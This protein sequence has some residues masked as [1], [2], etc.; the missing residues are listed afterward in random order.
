[1][2][3]TFRKSFNNPSAH[4]NAINNPEEL[5]DLTMSNLNDA[6][7][8]YALD[9]TTDGKFKAICLSGLVVGDN[10]GGVTAGAIEPAIVVGNTTTILVRPLQPFAETLPDPASSTSSVQLLKNIRLHK[11]F[12]AK[13]D[14]NEQLPSIPQFGE[15]VDCYYENGSISKSIYSNLRFEPSSIKGEIIP[16]YR[17]L[18]SMDFSQST[19]STF[20][21]NSPA[22]LG[23][24]NPGQKDPTPSAKLYDETD[25]IENK[26]NQI[27]KMN[28]NLHPV[29]ITYTKAIIY[30]IHSQ[31][32]GALYFASLYRSYQEQKEMRA[33]W[34]AWEN[35]GKIGKKPYAGRPAKAG[36]SNHNFGF[37]ADFAVGII[38]ANPPIAYNSKATKESW[39]ASGIPE[40]IESYGLRWGGR[41][42][43]NYD[44]IHFDIEL[45][46]KAT[47][48]I[49]KSTKPISN[50][51]SALKEIS[52]LSIE[53]VSLGVLPPQTGT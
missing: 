13:Y 3:A 38:G 24:P 15:I 5:F 12:T 53:T 16:G 26:A 51:T 32:N 47:K 30:D 25:D 29:M 9:S 19:A 20:N 31:L 39:L 7:Y 35:G 43:T 11:V 18:Q 33:K 28:E 8:D 52:K 40:I 10:V 44:P 21:Q 49:I 17:R 1:M 14:K 23:P 27:K 6:F 34:D 41:W 46:A 22:V 2:P 50:K 37:A 4:R 36:T 45:K 48:E 42:P